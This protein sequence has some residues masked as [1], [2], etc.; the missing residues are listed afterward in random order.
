MVQAAM[1][2]DGT[3]LYIWSA[4]AKLLEKVGTG[5]HGT[6]AGTVYERTDRL[7]ADIRALKGEEEGD[8]HKD[9]DEPGPPQDPATPGSPR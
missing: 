3:Y 5:L 8:E 6:V 2:T 1:A 4:E 9:G 7:L